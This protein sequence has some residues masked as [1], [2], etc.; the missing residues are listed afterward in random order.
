MHIDKRLQWVVGVQMAV[1]RLVTG[2]PDGIWV[3][4]GEDVEVL[5]DASRVARGLELAISRPAYWP[6]TLLIR[7]RAITPNASRADLGALHMRKL[8]GIAII[9]GSVSVGQ[10]EEGPGAA[11]FGEHHNYLG[12][13]C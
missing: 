11:R 3:P 7:P 1:G 9:L 5:V 10:D 8:G 4:Q 6:G 2:A 12:V 13:G